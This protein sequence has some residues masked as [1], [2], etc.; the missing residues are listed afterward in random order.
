MV[1]LEPLNALAKVFSSG[2][3][4]LPRKPI[5]E[6]SLPYPLASDV[7]VQ[8]FN[9]FIESKDRIGYKIE[10]KNGTV[11]IVDM[12]TAEHERVVCVLNRCFEVPNGGAHNLNSPLQLFGQSCKGI[13]SSLLDL[14][15]IDFISYPS[16]TVHESPSRDGSR[17]M[18]DLAVLPH[19]RFVPP[20]PIPHPGP[21]PSDT[22]G[23][24]YSRIMVEVA[25]S[26]TSSSLKDKCRK[27]KR[28]PYVR[29]ILGIK[30]YE[31]KDTRNAQGYRD[32]AMKAI[33]W[34]QGVRRQTWKFGTINKDGSPT[35]VNG[36]NALNDP[37]YIINI[38]VSD[39]FY[40]PPVPAIGYVPLAPPPAALMATNITI[41]LYDVQQVV[42]FAQPN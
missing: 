42:L 27:W 29:A 26:Q 16:H 38:P 25:V 7:S 5:S 30:L 40:D 28:E 36:C 33:L 24:P 6:T 32:R 9:S 15:L 34:R 23:N 11:Y 4:H 37:D 41:D 22:R 10:Y 1:R 31:I 13:P 17:I 39:V 14:W 21:P 12:P 2:Q 35:G 20:P 8:D 18:P 19:H 3:I